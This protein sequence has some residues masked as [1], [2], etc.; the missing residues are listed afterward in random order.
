M[1]NSKLLIGYGVF[2]FL[3]GL[4][5]FISNPAAAKTALISGS[6]FGGLSVVWGLLLAKGFGFARVAGIVT[7]MLLCGVFGWR[8]TV[9]WQRVMDGDPKAF[10]A[11]LI[12][13]MLIGS[14]ATF[15]RLLAKNA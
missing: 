4:A 14:I 12:T 5:G 10:A 15:A 11:S 3:C 9:S 2:L 6:V 7:A 13:L 8:S 1:T